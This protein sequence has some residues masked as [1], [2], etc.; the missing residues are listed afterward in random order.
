M[1]LLQAIYNLSCWLLQ[2]PIPNTLMPNTLM[3][4]D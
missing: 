2:K 4:N 1:G 3:P